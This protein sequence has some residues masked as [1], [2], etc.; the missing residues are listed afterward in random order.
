[1]K[2]LLI[3]IL[4]IA[5]GLN[6]FGQFSATMLISLDK[7]QKTFNVFSD[8]NRYRYEFTEGSQQVIVIVLKETDD[9]YMIMPKQKMAIRAKTDSQ[10]G[11]A[12][13]P[14]QQYDHFAEKGATEKIIGKERINGYECTKKELINT[15]KDD[16]GESNQLLFTIWYSEEFQFPVKIENHID[17]TSKSSMELLDIEPWKPGGD[18]FIIPEG[19]TVM[20][21]ET[22]MPEY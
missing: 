15:K 20:D 13:D 10:M 2:K 21:Q 11:I 3:L 12:T 19:Y 18:S 1:M 7:I 14:L 9:F 17:G 8:V 16:F 5:A 4:G 6:L 22:M